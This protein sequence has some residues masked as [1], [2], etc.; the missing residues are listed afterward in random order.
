MQA[1]K[2]SSKIN[3][4]QKGEI[5]AKVN[6][7][8]CYAKLF[9]NDRV[10][11]ILTNSNFTKSIYFDAIEAIVKHQDLRAPYAVLTLLK[12]KN[13]LPF[14]SEDFTNLMSKTPE[15]KAKNKLINK[16]PDKFWQLQKDFEPFDA[17][18]GSSSS[19]FSETTSNQENFIEDFPDY[20]LY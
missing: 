2:N 14:L 20:F 19:K 6:S 18:K 7:N 16:H 8:P 13:R 3:I 17:Q 1:D 12:E 15:L 4:S 10:E 11:K 9:L 5:L